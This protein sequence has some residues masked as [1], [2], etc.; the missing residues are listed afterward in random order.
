MLASLALFVG[1]V[2]EARAQTTNVKVPDSARAERFNQDT[3]LDRVPEE[4]KSTK[5][6]TIKKDVEFIKAPAGAEKIKFVL[7]S[8]KVTGLKAYKQHEISGL[9]KSYIGKEVTLKTVYDIANKITHKY[10]DDGYIFSKAI[11]PAQEIDKGDVKIKIHEGAI[12]SVKF[13][14]YLP[15]NFI[16]QNVKKRILAMKPLDVDVLESEI[17]KLNDLPGVSYRTVL[18]PSKVAGMV[19]L[20]V[21]GE[22]VKNKLNMSF[23]NSGSKFIG[24]LQYSAGVALYHSK[25]LPFNATNIDFTVTQPS[26]ELKFVS[27]TH[28]LP[29]NSYGTTFAVSGSYSNSE[30]GHT[31]TVN[32]IETD[33]YTG[34][35]T[36]AHPIKRTRTQTIRTDLSFTARNTDSDVLNTPLTRDR[37]RAVKLG[38]DLEQYDDFGGV[39][40]VNF[41]VTQGVNVFGASKRGDQNLSRSTGNPKFTKY[42]AV[43]TRLQSVGQS[44]AILGTAYGQWSDDSLLSSE[45]F[46]YGG[47]SIGKAYDASEIT[48]DKG[49]MGSVELRYYDVP[50]ALGAV[51]QPY[52]FYDIGKV[53][54]NDNASVREASAAS[55]GGGVRVT[56]A[57]SGLSGEFV[58]A[59]PLTKNQAT[60]I[61]GKSSNPRYLFEVGFNLDF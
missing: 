23:N 1:F 39:N 19:D 45:E 31:L 30:P 55:A 50:D 44:F 51:I 3:P 57:K 25:V 9:Y 15:K 56:H 60:P 17:L 18:K 8:L 12:H 40:F 48:G 13:K 41:D 43:V 20:T 49:V 38:V 36:V 29:V 22:K 58:A 34:T 61:H 14:G 46:G 7:R 53:W 37:V 5:P 32:E 2:S 33:S 52:I 21:I 42:E 26:K 28:T 27:L 47:K 54:Q 4:I 35:V 16:V 11:I 59:Q 24:P 6:K 10:H